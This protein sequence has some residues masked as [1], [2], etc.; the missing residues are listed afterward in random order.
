VD[1]RYYI[2]GS[3]GRRAWYANLL[4]NPAFTFHLKGSLTADL[5]ATAAPI[6]DAAAKQA[7]FAKI[8]WISDRVEPE[9]LG[10]WL[11]NSPLVEVHFT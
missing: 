1:D 4:A 6:I 2:T 7:V 8:P 11:S 10:K 3:P 5:P 9:E